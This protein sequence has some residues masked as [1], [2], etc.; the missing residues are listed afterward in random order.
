MNKKILVV[1][2]ERI[3]AEDIKS[4]LLNFQYEIVSIL[5][6]GEEALE[7]LKNGTKPDLI[8]MDI[9]LE[10]ELNGIQTAEDI[11]NNYGI[12][13]VFLTAYA[14]EK[15]FE[16]AAASDPYGYLLKPFEERELYITIEMA[17]YKV[18]MERRL[19]DNEKFLRK[20]IDTDP[21]IIFVK[22]KQGRYILV[23]QAMADLYCSSPDDMVGKTDLQFAEADLI[24][25]KEAE[26][27]YN[28]DNIILESKTKFENLEKK[29]TQKNGEYKIFQS[30]KVPLVIGNYKSGILGVSVD[31]TARKKAEEKEKKS[32]EKSEKLLRDIISTLTYAVEMRDPYTAGHQRRVALLAVAIATEMELPQN[33]IDGV[34]M[35]ADVHDIGK[36]KIP[37]E[38]L[39]RPGTLSDIEFSL[40]KHHPQSGYEILSSIDFPWP[41][42]DI[43]LQH[44]ERLDGSAYP[45]G[46]KGDEIL[47]EAKI[48]CVADVIEA[49]ASHRP[50][51]PSLGIEKAL[52]EIQKNRGKLYQPEIVDTCI[53]LFKEK[54]FKFGENSFN[55][56]YK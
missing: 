43:V 46:L 41:V 37:A 25:A 39:N 16:G 55:F 42:A 14:N 24:D 23:N 2:D 12:P 8:L 27:F 28:E 7:L 17:F 5:S 13:I 21:N 20:I 9:M 1:E 49:M 50:Y 36:I 53:A 48:I 33:I 31:I 32:F 18:K 44:H 19:R 15:I 56:S 45:N 6:K 22:D 35:A 3:I 47:L 51:R 40:I 29:F 30:T 34:S 10:G 11:Y 38:I 4:T 54:N 52:E 26:Q